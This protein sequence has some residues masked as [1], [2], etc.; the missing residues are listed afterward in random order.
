MCIFLEINETNNPILENKKE[1]IEID[2]EIEVTN[3]DAG[4]WLDSMLDDSD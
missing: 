4:H 1:S 3:R 2:A